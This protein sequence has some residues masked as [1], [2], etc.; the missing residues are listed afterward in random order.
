MTQ[1]SG[2]S[3]TRRSAL[4]LGT[5]SLLAAATGGSRAAGDAG[6]EIVAVDWAA[7][8]TLVTAGIEPIGIADLQGF[9]ETFPGAAIAA[10][11]AELGSRWEPNLELVEW[12]QPTLIYLASWSGM[13]RPLLE[14][15]AP[16]EVC[17]I[18]GT[19]GDPLANALAFAD[20]VLRTFPAAPDA[21]AVRS[22]QRALVSSK[23]RLRDLSGRRF[24]LLGLHGSGRF[25]NVYG[26]GSLPGS[27][28]AHLGLENGWTARTNGFGFANIGIEALIDR[29]ESRIVLIDQGA[30]TRRALRVLEKSAIWQAVPAVR[31][32]RILLSEPLSI[33]GGIASAARFADW[34][35]ATV[36]RDG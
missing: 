31:E 2:R 15:I 4:L 11:V 16:V 14:R 20:R 3:L 35:S 26:A 19:A 36:L 32:G 6:G 18:Y 17:D 10:S 25:A 33:F 27:V 34:L 5:A 21:G 22:L 8:E 9:R 12:L 7:A 29:A 30:Q 28:L 13:A 24:L 1:A 23:D